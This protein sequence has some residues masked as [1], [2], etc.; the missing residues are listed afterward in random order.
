MPF[1]TRALPRVATSA[2]LLAVGL[3]AT[4]RASA[5]FPTDQPTRLPALGRSAVSD[6]D[7]TALV[8]NPANLGFMPGVELRWTGMFLNEDAT[9]TYQGHAFALAFPIP[10]LSLATGLRLDLVSPPRAASQLL[11]G[12]D[13]ARYEW[14]T[15]GLAY[16]PSKAFSLGLSYQHSY[17]NQAAAHGLSSWSLG[18]TSR[19]SDYFGLAVVGQNLN[20]P[21]TDAG[22]YVDR[23]YNF[24][25]AIRPVRSSALEIGLE[26][27]YVDH[28]SGYWI[29]RATLGVEVPELG[30]L[31]G[32][33]SY[34]DPGNDVGRRQW[35]A[36]ASF[37]FHFNGSSGSGELAAGSLFGDGLGAEAKNKPQENLGFEIAAKGFRESA[38]AEA[39]R[40]ALRL[41][42]EDTPNVRG[43]TA[44]LRKLW[45]IAEH[46]PTVAAVVLELRTA[47]ADSMA[48]TQE[49]RDALFHL[50][51]AG[52]RVLCHLEDGDG[53]SL[54][55]CSAADRILLN[56]AGGIRFAGLKSRFMYFGG[57]LEKLGIKADFVRIGDH[58]SAPEQFMREG[59]SDVARADHIDLLQQVERNFTLD[60]AAGRHIDAVEL[61]KRIAKGPFVASEAKFAGLVD[62][63][64][65]DDQ[66]EDE[67]SALVGFPVR[68][69]EDRR[70]PRAPEFF[71]DDAGIAIIY[72]DGDMVD[73]RSQTI[74]L[75]GTRLVGSYTIAESL[76]KARENPK[77]G[78]VVL[79]VETGGGSAMAAD[80]IYREIQ[81]TT[82][83]KPVIVSMGSAAASGGYY[84]S[85]PGTHVFAN[86]LSITGS[87]GIFYG[88]ADVAELMR[89]IGVNVE[90]Y[91]TAPRADAESIFRP[92]TADEHTE[93]QRKVAQFY[94][95]F[96]TRVASGRKLSKAEVDAVGQGRVWTGQQA[97]D[98]KLV[99]ELGGLRQALALA[100][101]LGNIS[102]HGP[103]VELPPPDTT[104]LGR[105]LGIEG[106]KENPPAAAALLP[107]QF[108]DL[109][110]A[111]APFVA[112]AGDKPLALMELTS[113][114]P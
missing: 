39:P 23:A 43:H 79:R 95:V 25:V 10:F 34:S 54:Y 12:E 74:P 49:L 81:L 28:R 19:P 100:R 36:S 77:V 75:L 61:R 13:N 112:H 91:K 70:A 6:D 32:D 94:D 113:V 73:G 83:V 87:I 92:F 111:L 8:V 45:D 67:T 3:L 35:L 107:S 44:L 4:H 114:E 62:G 22:G 97:F 51:Q 68:L 84:I 18:A 110:R 31:R 40:Y 55:L 90:M 52:K 98:R 1:G 9:A 109:V 29:P 104:L 108:F 37:A 17:S 64:A 27:Q 41:R 65:F 69:L 86:P 103:I 105:L 47:P 85:A 96:L 72:V 2:L 33:F 78:A 60:V 76:K 50:R 15:W 59:A 26:T 57:L 56:P 89:R 24:A 102:D 11:F 20:A 53:S 106:I 82:K 63:F 5:Q 71:G 14:L 46:E 101:K 80:V 42:I 58:K 66:L 99:D 7:S 16:R 30:R 93:L 38:A 21:T 88:K 48:H